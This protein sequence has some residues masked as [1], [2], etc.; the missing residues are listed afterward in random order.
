MRQSVRCLRCL[1][2]TRERLD[3]EYNACVSLRRL[4]STSQIFYEKVLRRERACSRLVSVTREGHGLAQVTRK[5]VDFLGLV[6]RYKAVAA[7]TPGSETPE[8][9]GSPAGATVDRH[10]LSEPP[11]LTLWYNEKDMLEPLVVVVQARS[12]SLP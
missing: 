9:S 5:L 3:S 12:D 8:V 11:T 1:R 2:S 7:Q 10:G 4:G 6:H